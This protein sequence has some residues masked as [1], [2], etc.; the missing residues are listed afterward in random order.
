MRIM[1]GIDGR[2]DLPENNLDHLR[3]Y[4]GSRP[5]RIGNGASGQ[6]QND[7]LG[8]VLTAL[9]NARAHGLAETDDSWALQVAL[10]DHLAETW[11]TPDNGL[12]EI[13]G[14]SGDSPIRG[15]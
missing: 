11:D 1:Y 14:P 15:R 6:R 5:V 10:V 12:W 4:A 13:R 7:V 8:E 2:R 9:E 3:G